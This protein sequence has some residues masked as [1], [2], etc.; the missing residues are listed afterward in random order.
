MVELLTDEKTTLLTDETTL[1]DNETITFCGAEETAICD[2]VPNLEVTRMVNEEILSSELGG[3][4]LSTMI[5]D[6]AVFIGVAGSF[7][8][9]FPVLVEGKNDSF[10]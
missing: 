6:K 2:G 3:S 7:F 5:D 1:F 8:I 9:T 10:D 4:D